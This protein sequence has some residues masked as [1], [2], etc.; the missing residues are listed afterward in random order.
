MEIVK[1]CDLVWPSTTLPKL[2]VAGETL[3]PAAA[4]VPVKLIVSGDP[5]ASL[6][7]VIVPTA[8]PA[9]VGANFTLNV[10]VCEGFKVAGVVTPVTLNPVPAATM[11]EIC[12]AAFPVLVKVMFCE[13]LVPVATV[14]K[15]RLLGLAASFPIAAVDPVPVSATLTVGLVGSFDTR[16]IFPVTAPL[17]VGAKLTVTGTEVPALIVFGVVIPE[18]PNSD[19]V[20]VITETTKSDAPLFPTVRVSGS[21]VP[22]ETVP[23]SRAAGDEVRCDCAL[24]VTVPLRLSTNG[25]VPESP[26]TVKVPVTLPAAV[27]FNQTENVVLCPAAIGIGS[28]RPEI[29]HCELEG[30]AC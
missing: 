5:C 11:L 4:P 8:L 15:L 21:V 18:T 14:P 27:P 3:S 2:K 22:I 29:P 30:V 24:V 6:V 23:K 28:V 19:P 10:A 17:V 25:V 20:K 16:A 13:A 26:C 7:T 9:A 12:T 1:T